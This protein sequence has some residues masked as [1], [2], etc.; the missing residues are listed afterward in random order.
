MAEALEFRKM[1]FRFD[2]A[3]VPF[4]WNPANPGFSV[5]MNA[6]SFLAVAWERYITS[7]TRTLIEQIEDQR[8][9]DDARTFLGQEAQ[10]ASA[11][12]KH[13]R[14]LSRSYPA[15]EQVLDNA[16]ARFDR[17]R[18]EQPPRFHAAYMANI[19]A[20]FPALF[21]VL[22]DHR[23]DLFA[24]GDERVAS[25]LI[26]HF[27]EEIEHRSTA[28]E[29]YDAVVG[30]RWYRTRVM[31]QSL[32]HMAGLFQG[33]LRDFQTALPAELAAVV[34]PHEAVD[35]PTIGRR[36]LQG[37]A[38]RRAP[39]PTGGS[40]SAYVCV[41]NRR[42]LATLSRIAWSQTPFY[43]PEREK[44]PAAYGPWMDRFAG[45]QDMTRDF[46]RPAGSVQDPP[47]AA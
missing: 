29:I 42:L 15:L 46:G 45:G 24:D 37:R 17:L 18:A 1:Q 13:V 35:L 28:L 22:I 19:E 6:V 44:L 43:R 4:L 10:H 38:R 39:H 7:A 23:D 40:P 3:P 36:E 25:L 21:G 2:D 30:S 8:V 14:A 31:R 11:H 12:H 27:M 33:I 34:V 20:T 9:R 32:A 47:Y 41:S 16:V 26:W 5:Q